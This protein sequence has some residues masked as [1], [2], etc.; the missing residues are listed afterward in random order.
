MCWFVRLQ[1][2]GCDAQVRKK[3]T[4]LDALMGP[5][6]EMYALLRK[7]E[8]RVPG[9]ELDAV[10]DLRYS[11]R[12]LHELASAT[13][14]TLSHLQVDRRLPLLR[15]PSPAPAI[16]PRLI[17]QAAPLTFLMLRRRWASGIS[18]ARRSPPLWWTPGSS[19]VTGWPTAPWHP[20]C[21]RRMQ[22]CVSICSSRCSR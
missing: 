12:R 22:S 4:D 6:E 5:I 16:K 10:G 20:T 18:C 11:W 19:G 21:R 17:S 9:E 15:P 1:R 8:V 2:R 7:Y 3:E 13:S 14:N